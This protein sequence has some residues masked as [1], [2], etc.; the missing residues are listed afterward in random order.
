MDRFET[1][2]NLAEAFLWGFIALSC[3]VGA[4]RHSSRRRRLL[5]IASLTF[6]LF[7]FSDWI[8]ADSGAWWEPPWLLVL[9][10]ACVAT[11]ILTLRGWLR[12]SRTDHR[13]SGSD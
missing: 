3:A 4:I 2:F 13:S 11:L 8:E 7:G 10:V 9:K 12:L 5:V 6:A 1:L